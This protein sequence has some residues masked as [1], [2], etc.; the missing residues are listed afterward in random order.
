MLCLAG[1]LGGALW[2]YQRVTV[3][4]LT[5]ASARGENTLRL[6]TATLRGQLARYERLPELLAQQ[7]VIGNLLVAPDTMARVAAANQYLRA[8][9]GLL[10]ASDIY[11][12]QLDGNTLAASNF[13]TD[14]SFIGGNFAFRPYFLDAL[15][16]GQGRFFALG[17]TSLKRG[18]YFGAPVRV[19]GALRGVLVIKIDLD[20]IENAWGGGDY[21]VVVTDPEGIVFLSSNPEWRFRA[22]QPLTPARLA[23]TGATR[24]YATT[25]LSEIPHQMTAA[26]PELALM[27][28]PEAAEYVVVAEPMPDA[29]WTVNVL[30]NTASARVQARTTVSVG[31]L[32]VVLAALSVWIVRQQRQALAE[33]LH[34]QRSAREDLERRVAERTA[35]LGAVNT[36]LKGE[37]AERRAT[38]TVLRQTQADLIQAGKLAALGQM[39]AALSHEFNQPLAATRNYAENAQLLLDRGRVADARENVGRIVSLVDR[40]TRISRHLRNFARKPN[41]KLTEVELAPVIHAMQEIMAWR[42]E[43]TGAELKLDLGPAPVRVVAGPVRLQQV[44]VNLVSNALD[45]SEGAADRSLH[46]RAEVKGDM[47]RL[48][49]RDHGPGVSPGLGERIFDPFFSTKGVGKGLGLGLSISYNIMRDFGGG[50][51]VRN[52]PG[53]GA[54]FTLT[55]RAASASLE[56]AE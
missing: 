35:Q 34:L 56:A 24:R 53:G 48:I 20:E 49:L 11:V 10:G 31:L 41:A 43:A 29:G 25:P 54:E 22:L 1:M 39:S 37:V 19:D 30:L 52:H 7:R 16:E 9:A 26:A 12:M 42:F 45:A 38:E 14:V 2:L 47:V 46:L 33:R 36:A 27:T 15:S 3:Y 23:R 13:D 44:L 28:V 18:Y 5:E 17:T 6:A 50:L 4:Y 8:T 32:L 55:L 51:S 21:E 40:M